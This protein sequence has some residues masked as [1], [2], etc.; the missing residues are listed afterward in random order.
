MPRDCEIGHGEAREGSAHNGA[1]HGATGPSGAPPLSG[2]RPGGVSIDEPRP[3][4]SRRSVIA[5]DPRHQ[6]IQSKSV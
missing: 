5:L 2:E 4:A 1:D 6:K 3:A